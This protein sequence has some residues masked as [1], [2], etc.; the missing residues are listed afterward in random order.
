[1]RRLF[2]GSREQIEAYVG[3]AFQRLRAHVVTNAIRDH[4]L[5]AGGTAGTFGF[6]TTDELKAY[7]QKSTYVRFEGGRLRLTGKAVSERRRYRRT[8]RCKAPPA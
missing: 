2:H 5:Q 7:N 1:M 4:W 3:Q 8:S 6:P